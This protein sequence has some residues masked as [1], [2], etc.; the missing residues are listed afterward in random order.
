MT[1]T[2]SSELKLEDTAGA[3]TSCRHPRR[4]R[5]PHPCPS[6][7][8]AGSQST[9]QSN[10]HTT[11]LAQAPRLATSHAC[12]WKK[13]RHTSKQGTNAPDTPVFRVQ[14][15][16]TSRPHTHTQPSHHV[17]AIRDNQPRSTL[18]TCKL[19]AALTRPPPHP[20][21]H[22][23]HTPA[24]SKPTNPNTPTHKQTPAYTAHPHTSQ[25]PDTSVLGTAWVAL[26]LAPQ[27]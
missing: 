8:M 12:T 2:P 24:T 18:P 15:A 19:S 6:T 22:T 23:P 11:A 13:T 14:A 3:A 20:N 1:Y 5:P 26:L 21:T 7:W 25:P 10:R 9:C 17:T 4:C 16:H 27:L